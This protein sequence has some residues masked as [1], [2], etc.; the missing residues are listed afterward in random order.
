MPV[1]RRQLPLI[2]D[3]PQALSEGPGIFRLLS[4]CAIVLGD[5]P[6]AYS[7]KMW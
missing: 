1:P 2:V 3:G 7:L 6:A 5:F 4:A